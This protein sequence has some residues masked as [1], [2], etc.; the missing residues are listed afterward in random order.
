MQQLPLDDLII[1]FPRSSFQGLT[2]QFPEQGDRVKVNVTCRGL[3]GAVYWSR[4]SYPGSTPLWF[5]VGA[6]EVPK[7]LDEGIC[8][9]SLAQRACLICSPAYA[10]HPGD[11]QGV[12]V[13]PGVPVVFDVQLK[14]IV[15]W[16]EVGK[17]IWRMSAQ[18]PSSC[19]STI[20]RCP[21]G[22]Q[23]LQALFPDGS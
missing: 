15:S 14:E 4:L 13:P 20:I 1:K 8:K 16:M 23:S 10:A 21:H 22:T 6:G 12:G 17:E 18:G 9:V 7:G 2:T 19:V 5:T 11:P 3:D